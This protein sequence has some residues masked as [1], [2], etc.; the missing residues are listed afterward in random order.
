MPGERSIDQLGRLSETGR[1]DLYPKSNEKARSLFQRISELICF[2]E[3]LP[4]EQSG[5]WTK[6]EAGG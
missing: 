5:E 1:G 6:G 3:G 2:G 4:H